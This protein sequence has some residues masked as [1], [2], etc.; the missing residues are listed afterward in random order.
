LQWW[1]L[2]RV[3]LTPEQSGLCGC[4]QFI[5][6]L[7]QR[8]EL[9][10]GKVIKSSEEYSYYC[11]SL[12]ADEYS[13]AQLAGFIRGHWQACEI[14]S[15]YRRD[16]TLGEDASQI[17]GKNA[18]FAMASLRNLVLGLFELQKE[19]G[20]TQELY[21]P[22]WQRKMTASNAVKLIKNGG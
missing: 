17:S 4:W 16:V 11:A 8:Q 10:A 1:R 2:Q 6:V 9:R 12:A 7:R 14:G 13:A 20:K 15:H 3:T 21:V 18:A 5:A 19:N 22:S